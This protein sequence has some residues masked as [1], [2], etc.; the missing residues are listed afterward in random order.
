MREYLCSPKCGLSATAR[1]GRLLDIAP[2]PY[3]APEIAELT[4]YPLLQVR[5][6]L[7]CNSANDKIS[8]RRISRTTAGR[9][10]GRMMVEYWRGGMGVIDTFTVDNMMDD[11]TEGRLREGKRPVSWRDG[12]HTSWSIDE[13]DNVATMRG[14]SVVRLGKVESVSFAKTGVTVAVN[15][16][17]R[18]TFRRA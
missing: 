3:T 8:S 13:G 1:I 16:G 14:S 11:K 18:V 12:N 9:E 6:F 4:G 17:I 2:R 10:P 7:Q 5:G 15:N